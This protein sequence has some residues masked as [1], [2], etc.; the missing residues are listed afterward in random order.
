MAAN[1]R[2]FIHWWRDNG[3]GVLKNIMNKDDKIEMKRTCLIRSENV[4]WNFW[5]KQWGTSA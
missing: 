4:S 2:P 1:A 5:V 3:E